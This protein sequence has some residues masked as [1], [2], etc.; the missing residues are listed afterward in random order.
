MA[1]V[2]VMM[3][4][5]ALQP[6]SALASGGLSSIVLS[7]SMPGWVASPAGNDNGPLTSSSINALFTTL[8]SAQRA[9]MNQAVTSGELSGYV[10]IWR[11]EPLVGDGMV[12][13]A[14]Q[15]QSQYEISTLLG[16]F[17]RGAIAEIASARGSRF[18]VPGVTDASGF[19][20]DLTNDV[21]AVREYV[22]AFAKGDSAFLMTLVTSK[23]DL[24]AA[25]AVTLAQ[26]QWA[27]AP[28]SAVAPQTPPSVLADLL[29][30]VV[31][32][33]VVAMIGV[34]WL[35]E[36]TRRSVRDNPA[37]DVTRYA[38]YKHVP[39]DQRKAVRRSLVKLRLNGDD[40][41]NEA[42]VAWARHN[43]AIYWVTIASFVAM[44]A[45]ALIVSKG[46][47]YLVSILAIAM[48]VGALNLT[49]K[50]N[51]FIELQ[52][53]YAQLVVANAAAAIGA[54]PI[55]GPPTPDVPAPS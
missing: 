20:L 21:P 33:F 38:T 30:G 24:T 45:T 11:S 46:H 5:L 12:E 41:L 18:A 44:D 19:Y 26:R 47:V 10:R 2:A 17:D 8:T 37:L 39:K 29:W 27:L 31:A 43:I 3:L 28:G 7:K 32:A 13:L 23:Y 22:V 49:R 52:Q 34:L 54:A 55:G 35:R 36:R 48:F 25:D 50:K 14:F 1:A 15:S 16:G 42:A 9:Q 6:P 53:Q 40:H 4:V 51:R